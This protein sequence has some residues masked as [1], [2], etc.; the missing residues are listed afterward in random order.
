MSEAISLL[1]HKIGAPAEETDTR[2]RILEA[3]TLLF[4]AKGFAGVGI[5]EIAHAAE[6]HLA[7]V[8]YHFR[9][10]ENLWE[11]ALGFSFRFAGSQVAD[12]SKLLDEARQ[13]DSVDALLDILKRAMKR[14]LE[15]FLLPERD[16]GSLMMWEMVS[17]GQHL[18]TIVD[19]YVR[20]S[21]ILLREIL[22]QLLRTTDETRLDLWVTSIVGQCV[23]ARQS[24]PLIKILFNLKTREECAQ[25]A[26]DQTIDFC[27]SAIRGHIKDSW[28]DR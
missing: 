11:E 3:A 5:R 10:K 6:V 18:E 17:N 4:K 1:H 23:Y 19:K 15:D 12:L 16:S 28:P 20:P 24:L 9:N 13:T 26:T 2:T 7:A 14:F 22:R 21:R 27:M 8:N 25:L